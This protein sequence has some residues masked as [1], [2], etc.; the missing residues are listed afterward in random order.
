MNALERNL[1]V[2]A[3]AILL[4]TGLVVLRGSRVALTVVE[5]MPADGVQDASMR[6]RIAARFDDALASTADEIAVEI[7]PPISGTLQVS[8]DVIQFLPADAL[9]PNTSYT[10][11][12][13]GEIQGQNNGRLRDAVTW[14]FQTAQAQVLYSALDDANREQLFS[15]GVQFDAADGPSVGEPQQ[16]TDVPFGVWDFAVSPDGTQ[17]VYTVLGENGESDLWR[18]YRDAAEPEYLL[19][20]PGAACS[21][22]AWSVDGELLAFTRRSAATLD[23]TGGLSPPRLWLLDVQTGETAEVF[24]DGQTLG[25]SPFWSPSGAWLSYLAPDLDGVGVYNVD[26]GRRAFIATSTGESGVWRP[27]ADV[28]L[29]SILKQVGQQYRAH[30]HLVDPNLLD[31]ETEQG[32]NLSGEDAAVEDTSPAWSPDGEWIAFRRKELEGERASLGKQL[33]IMRADGSE[34]QPLTIAPEF[35]HGQ[36]VWSPDGRYLLYHRFPLQGPNIQ[37]IGRAHV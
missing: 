21:S 17:I 10:V 18:R 9:L 19:A 3:A 27:T 6:T 20:C 7:S 22:P 30:L 16:L 23:T 25:Y 14:H 34:Q 8:E 11:T 2:A 31:D 28:M 13:S 36:P 26:D 33:W 32:I 37:Q 5:V 4:L 12:V 1:I 15:M 35:D 24:P 29:V